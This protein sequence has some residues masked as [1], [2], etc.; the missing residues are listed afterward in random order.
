[1]SHDPDTANWYEVRFMGHCPDRRSYHSSF[2]HNRKLYILGGHDIREG[3]KDDLWVLDISKFK[4]F[5]KP[6][7]L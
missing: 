5:E 7:D 6:A 4:D 1:M 2:L 3:S